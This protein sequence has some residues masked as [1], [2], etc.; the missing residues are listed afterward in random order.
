MEILFFWVFKWLKKSYDKI[1][2]VLM[3]NKPHEQLCTRE[4]GSRFTLME[5]GIHKNSVVKKRENCSS[6][7]LRLNLFIMRNDKIK[8]VL[9]SCK[10]TWKIEEGKTEASLEPSMGLSVGLLNYKV[11]NRSGY[12]WLIFFFIYFLYMFLENLAKFYENNVKLHHF[13]NFKTL[14]EE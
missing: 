6:N 3:R 8:N 14:L 13:E 11:F 7:N 12:F 1:L 9:N 2:C 5:T 10:V 4:F